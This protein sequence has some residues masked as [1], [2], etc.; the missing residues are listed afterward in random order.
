MKKPVHGISGE[1][2]CLYVLPLFLYML[3]IFALSSISRYSGIPSWVFRLDKFIHTIEYYVL[4]Y[5]FMRVLLTSPHGFFAGAP[6]V[7]GIA[8]GVLCAISDE[9]HQS[10]VLGRHA[11]GIDFLFDMVGASL[12]VVTYRLVRYRVGW[13]RRIEETIEGG[14]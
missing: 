2:L 5:L 14:R 4:V 9:W 13:V 10:F 6:A 12:A 1:R 3:L 7:F 8:F 11:S